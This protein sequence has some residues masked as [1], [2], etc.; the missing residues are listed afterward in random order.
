MYIICSRLQPFQWESRGAKV[1]P[2]HFVLFPPQAA[3]RFVSLG[4]RT[5]AERS[6]HLLD[7]SILPT[8]PAGAFIHRTCL[9]AR[10][11]AVSGRCAESGKATQ[12]EVSQAARGGATKATGK[13]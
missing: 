9:Y 1:L 11:A 12:I 10:P 2:T 13:F 8:E 5:V 4:S 3:A 6:A 7:E